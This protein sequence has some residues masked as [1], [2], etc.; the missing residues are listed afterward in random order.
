MSNRKLEKGRTE[1]KEALQDFASYLRLERSL[2]RHTLSSYLSDLEQFT[3]YLAVNHASVGNCSAEEAFS[4]VTPSSVS[5][6][7]IAGFLQSG[8]QAGISPRSQA[9]RISSLKAFYKYMEIQ[10]GTTDPCS[11]IDSPKNTRYLPAVLSVEEVEAILNSVDLSQPEGPRNRAILEM[12]Y[13][14]GL[15]VSELI[16]LRLSD[17]FFKDA[18]I[19]VIGKGDKQ[20]LVP[21]GEPAIQAVENYIP[22]RWEVLQG[23]CKARGRHLEG[24][25]IHGSHSSGEDNP[26]FFGTNSVNIPDSQ[27][28][29]AVKNTLVSGKTS[30]PSAFA[31]ESDNTLFLNRRGGKLT[32]EM[33]FL[34]VRKQAEAAGI[35]KEISP[36][37]FRHSFATHLIENGADLRVV[38]QMLGHESILTTEIYTHVSSQQWMRNILE[39]HPMGHT[40]VVPR[41]KD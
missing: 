30:S 10:Y 12:L 3:Q 7:H 4:C 18:F 8:Y 19:R 29:R 31:A 5:P 28:T 9:R 2:S 11:A 34:I 20:R 39:H 21:I 38:Q 33:I 16:G 41:D 13:S 17:L 6:E 27:R 22:V 36:H 37:T 14:C 1:W 40:E 15:R 24:E 25:R 35:T 32:R 26:G 23:A